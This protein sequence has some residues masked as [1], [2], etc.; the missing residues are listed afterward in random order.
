MVRRLLRA[1]G[2]QASRRVP[3]RATGGKNRRYMRE[4]TPEN[5]VTKT[6]PLG[7]RKKYPQKYVF[8][9]G[10]K[11]RAANCF[12]FVRLNTLRAQSRLLRKNGYVDPKYCACA[13]ARQLIAV[14]KGAHIL[15]NGNENVEVH[16]PRP[17]QLT[18]NQRKT[19]LDACFPTICLSSYLYFFWWV[20]WPWVTM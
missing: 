6:R 1:A 10:G 8:A 16:T 13:T 17:T 20:G 4:C 18:K 9:C 19:R 3:R 11:K 7:H 2:A 12:A 15:I 14:L 5:Q